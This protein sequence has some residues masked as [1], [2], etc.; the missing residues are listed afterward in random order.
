MQ[1]KFVWTSSHWVSLKI[2]GKRRM[3]SNQHH[4]IHHLSTLHNQLP[5]FTLEVKVKD[6]QPTK[7]SKGIYI[8]SITHSCRTSPYNPNP[9]QVP[10][11]AK[12]D[13]PMQQ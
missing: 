10:P 13:L 9:F 5:L 6:A 3:S 7:E 4:I 12:N 11:Y 1:G 2:K 8:N